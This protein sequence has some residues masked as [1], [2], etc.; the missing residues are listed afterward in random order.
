M[1]F[2]YERTI[3]ME[4][5]LSYLGLKTEIEVRFIAD[6]ENKTR[7]ELEHRKRSLRGAPR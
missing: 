1:R 6:G 2:G 4:R 5:T 3:A 7:I